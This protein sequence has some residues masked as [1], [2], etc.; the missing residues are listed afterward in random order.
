MNR[1]GEIPYE[2]RRWPKVPWFCVEESDLHPQGE[3]ETYVEFCSMRI[4]G[5]RVKSDGVLPLPLGEGCSDAMISIRALETDEPGGVI[6][7]A[8]TNA[9]PIDYSP[10]IVPAHSNPRR[11]IDKDD[12]A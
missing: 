10:I 11:S 2:P 6:T 9:L 8:I 3:P 5:M 1:R 4:V 7:L 12:G